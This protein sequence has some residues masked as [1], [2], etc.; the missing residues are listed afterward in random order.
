MRVWYFH[1]GY[2]LCHLD[3]FALGGVPLPWIGLSICMLACTRGRL[4]PFHGLS[5]AFLA[6]MTVLTLATLAGEPGMVPGSYVTLR[7][8][9]LAGFFLVVNFVTL[10]AQSERGAAQLEIAI[11]RI[12]VVCAV[13]ALGVF[14]MHRLELGD[15]PR[16]RIGTGGLAQ[17]I[18]FTFEIGDL[19]QRALGTFREPSFL[20]MALVLPLAISIKGRQW[21]SAAAIATAA[22][23]TF[24]MG[25]LVGL[26]LGLAAA[27][28]FCLG[29]RHYPR[30]LAAAMVALVLL[31]AFASIQSDNP[32]LM[33]LQ[34]MAT[35]DLIDTS[36]GYVYANLGLLRESLLLG[37][38]IGHFEFA[39]ARELNLDLPVSTL[40]LFL[41]ILAA[42][43]IASLLLLL[44]WFLGP[45]MVVLGIREG[46]PVRESLVLLLPLN[47]FAVLYLTT[48]EELHIWHAI[49]LGLCLGRVSQIRRGRQSQAQ[50][51][52]ALDGAG[53]LGHTV[54]GRPKG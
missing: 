5:L 48:F 7:L 19:S 44:P 13:L 47:A 25:A 49:A 30:Y 46:L 2:V 50:A 54:H 1:A 35:L 53:L 14:L 37:D 17:P 18:A 3:A 9:N 21:V 15:L 33:R 29:T 52:A 36:R 22:Y 12:G 51:R 43:G 31:A 4:M 45:N 16:N 34:H 41:A 23:F 6:M 27:I 26:M 39:L 42:G 11:V 28:P 40:N 38:G 32:F 24:S 10:Q 20:A 8:A